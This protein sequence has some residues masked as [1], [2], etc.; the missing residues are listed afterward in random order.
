MA[1]D[2]EYFVYSNIEKSSRCYTSTLKLSEE[3]QVQLESLIKDNQPMATIGS[4][5]ISQT[6]GF[7]KLGIAEE[8]PISVI[9]IARNNTGVYRPSVQKSEGEAIPLLR[10]GIL[11]KRI[12]VKKRVQAQVA[13]ASKTGVQGAQTVLQR[14]RQLGKAGSS[15]GKRH[16]PQKPMDSETKVRVSKMKQVILGHLAL[17]GREGIALA[18]LRNKVQNCVAVEEE[19]FLHE[20]EKFANPGKNWIYVGKAKFIGQVKYNRD[21]KLCKFDKEK[22]EI[23]KR[24]VEHVK[25]SGCFPDLPATISPSI[26]KKPSK[27]KLDPVYLKKYPKIINHQQYLNLKASYIQKTQMYNTLVKELNMIKGKISLK[28]ALVETI[29][30]V[31]KRTELAQEI[32]QMIAE[33]GDEIK[34]KWESASELQKER[35]VLLNLVNTYCSEYQRLTSSTSVTAR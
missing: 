11:Q 21:A 26:N 29:K 9:D 3:A 18:S 20:V 23:V 8:M 2:Q 7:L 24:N 32:N 19:Y 33:K 25:S 15:V 13:K 22:L 1:T 10:I 34:R 14:K 4:L 5:R 17:A 6:G 12:T 35:D 28:K 30:D 27:N 16:K 31:R